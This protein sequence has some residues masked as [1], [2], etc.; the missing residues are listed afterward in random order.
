MCEQNSSWEKTMKILLWLKFVKVKWFINLGC[1]SSYKY[2]ARRLHG[3]EEIGKIRSENIQQMKKGRPE[4]VYSLP[5]NTM[6][7]YGIKTNQRT[8][9]EHT[10]KINEFLVALLLVAKNIGISLHA[11]PEHSL[12]GL[13]G[14]TAFEICSIKAEGQLISDAVICLERYADS[15]ALF[16][17]EHDN[18]SLEPLS[19]IK[20]NIKIYNH[21]SNG[22]FQVLFGFAFQG[23]RVLFVCVDKERANRIIEIAR[24]LNSGFV[25]AGVHEQVASD[26]FGEHWFGID[27]K[28]SS[29]IEVKK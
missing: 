22:I 6:K 24:D 10:M 11:I 2:A 23:F 18:Q 14:K 29:L 13:K 19:V 21:F 1:F 9:G 16:F 3:L 5:L 25:F 26:P 8:A 4:K 17:L 20:N 27:G 12:I 15:K 28:N 7:D